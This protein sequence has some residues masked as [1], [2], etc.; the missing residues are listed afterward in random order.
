MPDRSIVLQIASFGIVGLIATI[1]HIMIAWTASSALGTHFALSNLIGAIA[2]FVLSFFG[3]ACVTFR[4]PQSLI[5][6]APRYF[7]L[8]IVSF[9]LTSAIMAFVESHDLPLSLYALMVLCVVP[10][11]S[12]LL[13]K[14]WVFAPGSR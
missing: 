7:L 2:G 13:A 5:R 12:F 10:P 14:L 4:T 6:S 11:T 9:I 1:T 8:M 3:N